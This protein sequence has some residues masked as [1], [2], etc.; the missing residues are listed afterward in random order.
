MIGHYAYSRN[1]GNALHG[2]NWVPGVGH[3]CLGYSG[4]WSADQL[5]ALRQLSD[6]EG[7]VTVPDRPEQYLPNR[8]L[9]V[10]R[11]VRWQWDSP[12]TLRKAATVPIF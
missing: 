1:D 5:D 6:F 10:C 8:F 11:A 12:P 4:Q 7:A 3:I 2:P 9:P